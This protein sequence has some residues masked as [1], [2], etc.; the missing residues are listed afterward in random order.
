MRQAFGSYSQ[1]WAGKLTQAQRDRWNAAGAERLEPSAL[2]HPRQTD[3]GTVLHR[4]QFDPGVLPF[5]APVGT[6]RPGRV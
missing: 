1:Q 5:A 6:A 4:D 3:R 2:R